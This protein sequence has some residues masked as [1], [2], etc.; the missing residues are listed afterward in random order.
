MCVMGYLSFTCISV[1]TITIG[2]PIDKATVQAIQNPYDENKENIVFV[3][4]GLDAD[5]SKYAVNKIKKIFESPIG[6]SPLVKIYAKIKNTS[7]YQ[8]VYSSC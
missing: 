2:L 7:A 1:L 6:S 5:D 3:A 4:Y 8:N